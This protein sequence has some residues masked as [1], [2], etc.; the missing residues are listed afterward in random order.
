MVV[1]HK[2]SLDLVFGNLLF[3]LHSLLV[4]SFTGTVT[5]SFNSL[6]FMGHMAVCSGKGFVEF[7]LLMGSIFHFRGIIG[8]FLLLSSTSL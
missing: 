4:N 1:N 2:K 7:H 3:R 5:E 6:D 8:V